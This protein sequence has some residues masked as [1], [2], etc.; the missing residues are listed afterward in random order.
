[1]ETIFLKLLNMS[2]T[3]SYLVIL[4][5]LLRAIFSKAPRGMYCCL[6]SMVALRL[7]LPFSLESMLSLIPSTEPVPSEIIYT[8]IS[9]ITPGSTIAG[10]AVSPPAAQSLAPAVGASVNPMQILVAAASWIWI[11]GMAIMV[12]HALI[13]YLKIRKRTSEA[14]PGDGYF[15][16]DHIETPFILGTLRPK[17]FLPSDMDAQDQFYVLAHEQAHLSRKD[18]LWKPLGYLLLTVYWFNPILWM[19]YVFFCRDIELACDE[20]VI[21]TLGSSSKKAYSQALIHCSAPKH[22]VAACPL[23]FGEVGVKKR[24]QTILHYRAPG[25]WVIVIAAVLCVLAAVCFLTDPREES[26]PGSVPG[27]TNETDGSISLIVE[28]PAPSRVTVRFLQSG[29]TP[30]QVCYLR[31]GYSLEQET[32]DGWVRLN[33]EQRYDEGLLDPIDFNWYRQDSNGMMLAW[34]NIPPLGEGHYRIG[35]DI[36]IE[37]T[38]QQQ[39][40]RR[41]Y[42]EFALPPA[43]SQNGKLPL[44]AIPETYSQEEA[45]LDGCFVISEGRVSHGLDLWTAFQDKLSRRESAS[46]RLCKAAVLGDMTPVDEIYDIDYD[47]TVFTVTWFSDNQLKSMDYPYLIHD[48]GRQPEAGYYDQWEKWILAKSQSS[49]E[50]LEAGSQPY[51]AIYENRSH[52]PT[53]LPFQENAVKVRLEFEGT[54]YVEIT[55]PAAIQDIAQL[56]RSADYCYGGIKTHNIGIRLDLIA[57]DSIGNFVKIELDPEYDSCRVGE[58]YFDYGKPDEEEYILKLWKLLGI[59]QWPQAV[60][61]KYPNAY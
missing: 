54:T 10:Q 36:T 20:K 51:L 55:D 42:G 7:L 58:D 34:E 17:I 25:F 15:S 50:E 35:M 41:I 26:R 59:D 6:W 30:D 5:V 16:C 56:F 22:L 9:V 33:P 39:E 11:L 31:P 32:A 57:E 28:N 1:M 37:D 4:I 48:M 53:G 24:I 13:S 21:R 38:D 52:T 19:A 44:N 61:D 46:L 8:E 12:L 14:V 23:A 40:N 3:A 29:E 47:G 60:Y 2:I 49:L 45:D 18:N 43:K 27:S